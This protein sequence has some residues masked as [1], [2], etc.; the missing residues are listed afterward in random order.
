MREIHAAW[1][2]ELEPLDPNPQP[3]A[4]AVRAQGSRAQT[5]IRSGTSPRVRATAKRPASVNAGDVLYNTVN[6]NE[7]QALLA[8][9]GNATGR[10]ARPVTIER[11]VYRDLGSVNGTRCMHALSE[12]GA[13]GPGASQQTVDKGI[14]A[15]NPSAV[16]FVGIAF[17][18]DDRKQAIGDILLAKR[19]RLY[20][21]QRVGKSIVLRG[22][23]THSSTWLV[24]HFNGFAQT[25]WSGAPVRFGLV[26]SGEKLVDNMDY[27]AQLQKLEPEAVGGEMEGAGL[28][29]A[30]SEAKVDWIL[31]KAICDWADGQKSKNMKARQQKAA[32]SAADF[33]LQAL[34]W[35]PLRH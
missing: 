16:I 7:T 5:A 30:S 6:V 2:A 25:A 21:L 19:L 20:D 14:R 28:Y 27:R 1:Q 24:N 32:R 12:M 4:S 34:Q 29:V 15:L 22:D 31:I 11:R 33:V 9:F 18:M 3:V 8:A 26:L 10:K 17:G 35:A 13:G 23:K